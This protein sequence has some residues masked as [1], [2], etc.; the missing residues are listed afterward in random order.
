MPKET[1]HTDDGL[2]ALV[3][4]RKHNEHAEFPNTP[5]HVQIAT[6]NPSI[7]DPDQTGA[8]G[9]YVDVD[10]DQIDY[11]IAV[12]RKAKRQAYPATAPKVSCTYTR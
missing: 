11:L 12:L 3:K 6:I 1:L 8:A 9:F 5:G 10:A 2:Q 7:E 4:W